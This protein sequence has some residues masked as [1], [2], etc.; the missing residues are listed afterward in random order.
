LCSGFGDRPEFRVLLAESQGITAGFALFFNYYSTWQGAGLYLED[1]FVRPE[2]RGR[3]V[4]KTLVASVAFL[5]E[6]ESRSFVRWSVLGWNEPAV[7]L[8]RKLGADFLEQWRT[9][10]LEGENLKRLTRG[11]STRVETHVDH[12]KSR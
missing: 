8:Y 11:L 3:G 12:R 1:L 6:R 5:A 7:A 10:S 2:Y 4:G 9:V